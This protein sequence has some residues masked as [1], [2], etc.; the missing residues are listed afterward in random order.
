ML[1]LCRHWQ[2]LDY[3]GGDDGASPAGP[4]SDM[5]SIRIVP[6]LRALPANLSVLRL[7]PNQFPVNRRRLFLALRA[8][9]I[10]AKA[11]GRYKLT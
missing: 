2:N 8:A 4:V 1:R 10:K 7:D 9:E 11:T 3:D 6:E 5:Y